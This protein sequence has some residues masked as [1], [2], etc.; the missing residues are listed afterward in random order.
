MTVAVRAQACEADPVSLIARAQWIR[1]YIKRWDIVIRSAIRAV[2]KGRAGEAG[3][4]SLDDGVAVA[5]L[6]PEPIGIDD[7]VVGGGCSQPFQRQGILHTRPAHAAVEDPAACGR[8][9]RLDGPDRV[10]GEVQGSKIKGDCVA[11]SLVKS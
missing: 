5:G 3:S 11:M 9:P 1:V 7:E 2:Q 6:S 10:V 4:E 8:S